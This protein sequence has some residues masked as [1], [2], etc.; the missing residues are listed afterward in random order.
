MKILYLLFLVIISPALIGQQKEYA[1]TDLSQPITFLGDTIVYNNDTIK[2]HSKSFFIDGNLSDEF[3]AEYP[4]VFNSI[5]SAVK[6][7]TNGSESEP[8][9]LY[10]APWVYWIDDPDDPQVRKP[11]S[12]DLAPYGMKIDCEWLTFYGLNNDPGNVILAC[13]SG[14]TIGAEGNFTMFRFRGDGTKSE[15]I[16]FGNYCNVDLEFPLN[17]DLSRKKRASAIV[18][19]QLIHCDGDKIYAKNTHFIS[20]LNLCP[21]VGGKRTL[22]EN[23]HFECTDDALSGSA[24]YLN[25]TLTFFSSKPFYHTRGTGAFFLNCDIITYTTGKQFFTK[26]G[27]QLTLIDTRMKG[28]ENLYIGWRDTPPNT[29]RNYQSN[30]Q[31]NQSHYLIGQENPALTVDLSN[32]KIIAA[33]KLTTEEK[34]IYN[35]YNLL[36]GED[37]WDPRGVKPVIENL[38]KTKGDNLIDLPVQLKIKGLKSEIE[39]SKEMDTLLVEAYRYGNYPLNDYKVNWTILNSDTAYASLKVIEGGKSCIVIPKNKTD[40]SKSIIVLAH[41]NLGLEAAYEVKILPRVLPAPGFKKFPMI[42]TGQPGI[43]FIDY[44]LDAIYDDVSDVT[45]YRSPN[46]NTD[47]A[48]E[49]KVT[50]ED[51]PLRHYE[52]TMAD[53]GYYILAA[54]S[55]RHIRSEPGKTIKIITSVPVDQSHVYTQSNSVEIDV[56]SMSAKN[57]DKAL[58]GQWT[59]KPVPGS[60]ESESQGWYFGEGKDGAAG[61]K[62]IMPGRNG[63][64]LYTPLNDSVSK[65]KLELQIAPFKTAG[66]GFSIA[67][68]YMDVLLKFNTET[69]SGYGL[70]FIRTTKYGNAVDA[71]FV[72]YTDG[73]AIPISE[74]VSTSCYRTPLNIILTYQEGKLMAKANSESNYDISGYEPIILGEVYLESA[75]PDNGEGGFGIWYDGGANMVITKMKADWE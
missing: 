62:G 4:F 35:T 2:L 46:L 58:P 5:Q 67:P 19:A 13:N 68:L 63:I 45:W 64:L 29:V 47:D 39:T 21:F 11:A 33:Y 65:M 7:I 53:T 6:E 52:L 38:Q 24:V 57:Q 74:P 51:K 66:Q 34:V 43:L 8:M 41:D 40:Y 48:I 61:I 12:E 75:L 27:G 1:S 54:I 25:S 16:T 31:Y 28:E 37:D 69:L 42:K 9:T 26:A 59:L 71:L 3:C 22:F 73:N 36:R 10:I 23:C 30:F 14:Q 50:R 55:P 49:V 15:N 32:K 70:R 44:E 17:P 72:K 60:S 18:Q 20:R 56:S